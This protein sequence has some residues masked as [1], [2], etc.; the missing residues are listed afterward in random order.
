MVR[1]TAFFAAGVLTAIHFPSLVPL[2]VLTVFLTILS[3]VYLIIWFAINRSPALKPTSGI[4]G[5]ILVSGFGYATILLHDA[6]R[7]PDSYRRLSVPVSGYRVS[8]SAPVEIRTSGYRSTGELSAVKTSGGWIPVC[9][10]VMLYWP[11][12]AHADML[13]HGDQ[14]LVAGEPELVPGPRNPEEFDYRTF[15]AR[16]NIFHQDFLQS[17]KWVV[18]EASVDRSPKYYATEARRW[19]LQVIGRLVEGEREKAIVAAF[20]IGVTEGI[21]DDLRQAY[22]AGGAMHALAVSGMHVSILYGVLL[23]VLK[24]LE[25]GKGGSWT[26]AAISLVVLWMFGFVTGLSPSVLRAVTMFSFVAVAKPLK[27]ISGI[28]NTLAASAFVLLLFDP[29]LLLSAG[30]QLS[31]LA[32]L[33]IVL[34]YRPIYHLWEAPWAWADWVWQITCVSIAAQIATLPVTLYYFHQFPVYF[35]LA[36]VFVIPASTLIL[37]GGLLMLLV[38]PLPLVAGGVARVLEWM[39]WLLNEGLFFVG[40]LPGSVIY[41]IHTSLLQAICLGGIAIAVYFL[42]SSKKFGWVWMMG[43]LAILIS[44]EDWRRQDT[45]SLFTVYHVPRSAAL[46]WRVGGVAHTLLDSVLRKDAGKIGYHIRPSQLAARLRLVSESNLPGNPSLTLCEV[47]GWSFLRI[48]ARDVRWPAPFKV[49]YLIIGNNAVRSLETLSGTITF[50]Y[51]ILDSSNSMSYARRI[52]EEAER[53]GVRCYSVQE[54][55]AFVREL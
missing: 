24:P 19:I 53:L 29:W 9:G 12:T 42:M 43:C 32:V 14:L 40:H 37:L 13:R 51:L 25:R 10:K 46:E 6:S 47:E 39:I 26:V 2:S 3:L 4:I 41:P 15:L 11:A 48:G 28:Y 8:L 5:L 17:G 22:A 18:A 1:V 16:R 23:F 30:F 21:D 35:L 38:S 20:V 50:D 36:N 55:G 45:P 49:D 33:G 31:Y 27:R 52:G 54:K 34:F 7:S 44:F